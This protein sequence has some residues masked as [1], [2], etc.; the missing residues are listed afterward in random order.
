MSDEKKYQSLLK[1]ME[2]FRI[3]DK[4]T[5]AQAGNKW[6]RRY[7]NT[8]MDVATYI[9]DKNP[10]YRSLLRKAESI[11]RK[12]DIEGKYTRGSKGEADAR[13]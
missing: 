2:A 4:V 11:E 7:H 8:M 6:L 1:Q 10:Q 5:D 9:R 3:P 12:W 13:K